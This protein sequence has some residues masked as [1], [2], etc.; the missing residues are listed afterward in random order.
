[1]NDKKGMV[2]DVSY[3]DFLTFEDFAKYLTKYGYKYD[4]D[5]DSDCNKLREIILTLCSDHI[6]RATFYYSGLAL[7]DK[8]EFEGKENFKYI[9]TKKVNVSGNFIVE[10]DSLVKLLKTNIPIY[11][12]GQTFHTCTAIE[13]EGITQ[14]SYTENKGEDKNI[15]FSVR[16]G[17]DTNSPTIKI[18]DLLYLRADID[19][20]F[21][22]GF[23]SGFSNNDE[24]D[25]LSQQLETDNENLVKAQVR[26]TELETELEQVKSQLKDQTDKPANVAIDEGQGDTLLI[27]GAVMDCIE[28]IAK[29]NY[30]Q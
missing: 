6:L 10:K 2:M 22:H 13:I 29:P 30:T 19:K 21:N 23:L 16:I 5:S 27:L 20:A 8:G 9:S 11:L 24:I 3:R 7:V 15:Y 25:L 12:D 4:L 18:R 17:G 26:I 1:M 14:I 28:S